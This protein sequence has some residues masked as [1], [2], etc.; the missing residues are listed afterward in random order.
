MAAEH[1]HGF[2]GPIAFE[3]HKTEIVQRRSMLRPYRQD[4]AKTYGRILAASLLKPPDT[5]Q[6]ICVE[7][8]GIG[9]K[10]RQVQPLC[11]SELAGIARIQGLVKKL[12]QPH[13]ADSSKRISISRC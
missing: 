13:R 8:S 5:N 11:F 4:F 1:L 2:L 3:K 10:H 6:M 7:I 9:G 12:L